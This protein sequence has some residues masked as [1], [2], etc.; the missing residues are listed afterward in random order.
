MIKKN[1]KK[2]KI[3]KIVF[4][5]SNVHLIKVKY[6]LKPL[7]PTKKIFPLKIYLHSTKRKLKTFKFSNIF[8]FKMR[9][10]FS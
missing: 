1:K 8:S 7:K 3:L 9:L 2:I 5:S 10:T 4:T 6:Q